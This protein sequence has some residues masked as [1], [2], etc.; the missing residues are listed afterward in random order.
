MRIL[1]VDHGQKRIG[2]AVSDQTGAISR[3]LTILVHRSRQDDVQRTLDLAAGQGAR[4][5]VVGQSLDEDGVPNLAGRQAARF[6]E[7][8]GTKGNIP[9]VL[10]DESMSSWDATRARIAA[11]ARR[12]RRRAAVDAAAAATILQSY[13]DAHAAAGE[14]QQED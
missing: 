1:G 10:W 13:L 14:G 6:A 5:I 2:I 4:L 7:L 12:K 3:P 11:G 9:V 8:L